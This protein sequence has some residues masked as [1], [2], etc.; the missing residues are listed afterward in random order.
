VASTEE[1]TR[2]LDYDEFAK[3]SRT[4]RAVIRDLTVIG[5]AATAIPD[6][7]IERHAEVPW[8][9]M[10]DMRNV[11]VRQY[12]GVDL[13]IVWD[14]VRNDLPP[15]VEPLIRVLR[16]GPEEETWSR[17]TAGLRA[18]GCSSVAVGDSRRRRF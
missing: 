11:V 2:G 8:A 5:E 16:N 7:L 14:T 1:Y 9:D 18:A 4:A 13:H 15:L 10:R 12:F 3:A 17:G 6:W